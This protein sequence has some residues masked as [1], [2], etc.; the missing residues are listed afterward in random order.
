MNMA[1]RYQKAIAVA[2]LTLNV[3]GA[4]VVAVSGA[5][6]HSRVFFGPALSV[7]ALV[8]V[9]THQQWKQSAPNSLGE[10]NVRYS[11]KDLEF[12]QRNRVIAPVAV[13]PPVSITLGT[14]RSRIRPSYA[15]RLPRDNSPAPPSQLQSKN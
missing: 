1:G 15:G 12:I 5:C 2:L 10:A 4:R 11:A 6:E 7:R 3:S 8:K 13:L 9:V 14:E